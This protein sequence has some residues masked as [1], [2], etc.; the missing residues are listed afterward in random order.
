MPN[1]LRGKVKS[2]RGA[3][4]TLLIIAQERRLAWTGVAVGWREADGSQVYSGA[5]AK[6]LGLFLSLVIS[7]SFNLKIRNPLPDHLYNS[8]G[9]AHSRN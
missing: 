7:T 2:R 1:V 4:L 3:H 9:L 8:H 6:N 5:R